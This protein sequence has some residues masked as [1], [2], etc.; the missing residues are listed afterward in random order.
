MGDSASHPLVCSALYYRGLHSN[1][2]Y[3]EEAKDLQAGVLYPVQITEGFIQSQ[4]L[5]EE[6][7]GTNYTKKAQQERMSV[8]FDPVQTETY[9]QLKKLDEVKDSVYSVKAKEIAAHPKPIDKTPEMEIAQSLA[10]F[11]KAL[12]HRQAKKLAEKYHLSMDDMR[13]EHSL[14]VADAIS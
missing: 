5:K 10:P 7:C 4:K 8:K 1:A 3:K 13:I 9:E 12:Y 6:L 2:L 11:S 14:K